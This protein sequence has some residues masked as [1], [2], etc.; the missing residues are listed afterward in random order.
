[1]DLAIKEIRED[2]DEFETR[3]ALAR[4]RLSEL[5]EGRLPFK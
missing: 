4:S 2:I 5:P 1:M 3:I